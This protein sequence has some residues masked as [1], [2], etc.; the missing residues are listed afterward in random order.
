MKFTDA[1]IS[2]KGLFFKNVLQNINFVVKRGD[3]VAVIG[4]NGG[5]KST[6][7]RLLL[8]LLKPTSGE[9]RLFN[10]PQ[11]KLCEH[12]Q[13]GYVPQRAAQMD[14]NFPITVEEVVRLGVAHKSSLFYKE[15]VEDREH[16]GRMMEQMGV[17]EL[18]KRRI[19]ELSGGQRQR[20]MIARA[21]VGRPK[22]LILDE[23]N[24]GVDAHSQRKFYDLLK[25]LNQDEKITILFVTHDLG[26]IAEDVNSALCVNQTLLSN[27][28]PHELLNCSEI[29]K[30]YGVDMR[31][32]CHHH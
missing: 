8:G 24:T 2:V 12:R 16:I 6:L 13:I 30:L 29:S 22:V 9:I 5:G 1:V 27:Y 10:K 15:S 25:K 4:P 17:V 20:V 23:P 26:V 21:L 28:N 19:S 18:K 7:M 31:I 3:Y 32:V 14:L 11:K